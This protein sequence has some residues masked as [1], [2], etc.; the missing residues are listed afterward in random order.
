MINIDH[1]INLLGQLNMLNSSMGDL[2]LQ[3][4][5]YYEWYGCAENIRLAVLIEQP[6]IKKEVWEE[7]YIIKYA[8][9]LE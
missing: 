5:A 9:L 3:G 7:S 6:I 8:W 4:G 2:R 1:A